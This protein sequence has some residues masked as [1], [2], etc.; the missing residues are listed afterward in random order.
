LW[1]PT[2]TKHQILPILLNTVAFIFCG[3]GDFFLD[4]QR[5]FVKEIGDV[6]FLV[7]IVSFLIAQLIFAV[8]FSLELSENSFKF[9]V[10]FSIVSMIPFFFLLVSAFALIFAG[11]K[12]KG[13]LIVGVM[14]YAL[15]IA[16][17]GWRALAKKNSDLGLVRLIGSIIFIISD[18]TIAFNIF[19]DYFKIMGLPRPFISF[20]IMLTY[21]I[22]L[23]S[24]TFSF[25]D[26]QQEI[27]QEQ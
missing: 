8:L 23:Y 21:W 11:G 2:Y 22:A 14:F 3:F 17:M 25:R 6:I 1:L 4:L 7:G 19:T 9:K 5:F 12:L 27:I 16:T 15:A 20:F 10:P 18:L 26:Y 13:F 24:F